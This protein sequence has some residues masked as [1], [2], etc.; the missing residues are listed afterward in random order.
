MQY[1][2]QRFISGETLA[3]L[4]VVLYCPLTRALG[5]FQ[6]KLC[7]LY[8]PP[9][10]ETKVQVSELMALAPAT[11]SAVLPGFR[12]SLVGFFVISR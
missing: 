8:S 10:G 11:N 9:L 4:R 3:T 2:P 7:T 5:K 1:T 6:A 12:F